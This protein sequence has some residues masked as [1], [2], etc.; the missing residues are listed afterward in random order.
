MTHVL[1][2]EDALKLTK[3]RYYKTTNKLISFNAYVILSTVKFEGVEISKYKQTEN[4]FYEEPL[5]Y[6][7]AHKIIYYL[8]FVNKKVIFIAIAIISLLPKK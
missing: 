3:N 8:C 2:R 5:K 1:C 6:L 4:R 7:F